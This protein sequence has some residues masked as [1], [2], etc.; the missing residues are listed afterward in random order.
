[1]LAPRSSPLALQA[2]TLHRIADGAG[3]TILC[4]QGAIWVTQAQYPTPT[5]TSGSRQLLTIWVLG[6]Q[7][8]RVSIATRETGKR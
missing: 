8:A 3:L 1:M 5:T 6:P 2:R 7:A 4:L